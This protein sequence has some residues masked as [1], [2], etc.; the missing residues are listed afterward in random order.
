MFCIE[1]LLRFYG[2]GDNSNNSNRLYYCT[3]LSAR[4]AV[5]ESVNKWES[6]FIKRG[7]TCP[8]VRGVGW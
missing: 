3:F 2:S 1:I 5:S 8:E 6:G 4:L 7:S